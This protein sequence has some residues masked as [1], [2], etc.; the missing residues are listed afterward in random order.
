MVEAPDLGVLGG[1][2]YIKLI[3]QDPWECSN[4]CIVRG[5]IIKGER[6]NLLEQPHVSQVEL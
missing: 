6:N 1:E 2:L 3:L 5:R 4:K